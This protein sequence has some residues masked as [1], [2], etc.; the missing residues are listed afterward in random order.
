MYWLCSDWQTQDRRECTS[1]PWWWEASERWRE[2]DQD[3]NNELT[4]ESG[5]RY[6]KIFFLEKY[7]GAECSATKIMATL[8]KLGK[9]G[10]LEPNLN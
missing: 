7:T 6:E 5:E 2:R 4:W 8:E 10:I 1:E 9:W 3:G